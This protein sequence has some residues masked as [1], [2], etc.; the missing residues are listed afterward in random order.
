MTPLFNKTG[1]GNLR[2]GD[3]L[4]A[5]L[6]FAIALHMTLVPYKVQVVEIPVTTVIEKQV[7]VKV[8]KYLTSSDKRQIECLTQNAYFEA[9][10]QST[11]GKI[12]VSNVVM[13]RAKDGEFPKTPCAVINQKRS[14]VCQFSWVCEGGKH[15]SNNRTLRESRKVAE[16]VY[17]HNVGDVTRGA[18]FYHAN[19]VRPYWSYKFD[20]TVQIG[21]HVFY[22]DS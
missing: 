10:N 7:V 4:T 14:G 12:A 16:Q 1:V 22:K 17:L 2:F 6:V 9:G 19:Y 11:K 3:G 20:K 21:D 18:L 15:I 8:P 13:N 5:G